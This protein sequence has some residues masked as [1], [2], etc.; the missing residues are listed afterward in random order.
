MDRVRVTDATASY[1]IDIDVQF[2]PAMVSFD[3]L[4]AAM[5]AAYRQAHT[6][7]HAAL[8]AAGGLCEAHDSP[9]DG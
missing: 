1:S 2:D 7:V 5:T 6:E 4:W 8:N 3:E 9:L